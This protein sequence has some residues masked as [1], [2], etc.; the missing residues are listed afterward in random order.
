M[1]SIWNA[2]KQFSFE[3]AMKMFPDLQILIVIA[4]I[5][6]LACSGGT[7]GFIIRFIIKK[8]M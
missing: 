8:L 2:I 6:F 5:I 7:M 1:E 3:M 4:L